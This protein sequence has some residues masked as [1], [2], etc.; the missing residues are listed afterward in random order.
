MHMRRLSVIAFFSFLAALHPHAQYNVRPSDPAI[1]AE[2]VTA[3]PAAK[4][5]APIVVDVYVQNLAKEDI[6][7][8][9]FSPVSSSVGTPSFSIVRIPQGDE[10]QLPPGLFTNIPDDWDNWYQPHTAPGERFVL[11]AGA[12]IHLLHGDLRRTVQ[13]A[14]EYCQEELA[15]GR[16]LEQPD[17]VLTKKEYQKVVQFAQLFAA[18]GEFDLTVWAYAKSNTVRIQVAPSRGEAPRAPS[19]LTRKAEAQTRNIRALYQDEAFSFVGRHYG[20]GKDP[21]AE[22]VPGL[23]VKSN[24]NDRWIEITAISTEGGRFGRVSPDMVV[25]VHWDYTPFANRPYIDQPLKT[26]GSIMFPD[27]I[28]YDSK[29]GRY[30]LRH[31]SSWAETHPGAVTVLYVLRADLIAAF[32]K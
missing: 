16:L 27:R 4:P 25:S 2:L 8:D 7:R 24:A 12:R 32:E 6:R 29:T 20:D 26:P 18:G 13:A 21:A 23:F 17:A 11:P 3:T 19:I 14:G 30:E 1:K 10:V 5:G 28:L 22:T 9:R 31:A 15:R